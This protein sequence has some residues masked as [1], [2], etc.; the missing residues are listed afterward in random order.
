MYICKYRE[1]EKKYDER[2]MIFFKNNIN[3]YQGSF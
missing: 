3:M 1:R 2:T